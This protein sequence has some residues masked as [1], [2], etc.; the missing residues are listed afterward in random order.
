[1]QC[2][3]AIL[4]SVACPALQYFSTLSHRLQN[5][6]KKK[7]ITEYEIWVLIFSTSFVGNISHSRQKRAI[8]SKN[9]YFS[10]CKVTFILSPLNANL[11]SPTDFRKIL[12]FRISWKSLQWEPSFSMRTDRM[13][14]VTKLIIA[15]RNFPNAYKNGGGGR[16]GI[17]FFSTNGI[18][19]VI[20][21]QTS[22]T[23]QFVIKT[24]PA[25]TVLATSGSL[26][27]TWPVWRPA[28]T[29]LG[30]LDIMQYQLYGDWL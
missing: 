15:F 5:F 2:A 28:P 8:C 29:S 21:P 17:E 10:S 22:W 27:V 6:R 16:G 14:D 11:I 30:T 25:I 4:S 26:R 3:C 1:M 19:M 18:C 23:V 12:R 24:E 20:L 9:V 13:T 7:K